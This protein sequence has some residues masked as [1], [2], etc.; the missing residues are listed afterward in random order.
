MPLQ[1]TCNGAVSDC[2]AIRKV[3]CEI[4]GSCIRMGTLLEHTRI[5]QTQS[6]TTLWKHVSIHKY[7]TGTA[8]LHSE[9]NINQKRP[10]KEFY[11]LQ[12]EL[13]EF[14]KEPYIF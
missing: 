11:S 4:Y 8:P 6:A 3:P 5:Q 12:T 10:S 2:V 7:S 9:E 14:W 13:I 1:R